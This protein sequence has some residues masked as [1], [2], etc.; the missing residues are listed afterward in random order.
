VI[1]SIEKMQKI[2]VLGGGSWGTAIAKMLTEKGYDTI[3]WMRNKEN[4]KEIIDT[5]LNKKYL[6]NILLPKELKV[7]TD[8]NKSIRD[9]DLLIFAIPTQNIRS[10]LQEIKDDIAENQIVCNVAKG[11]EA[12][13]H[14]RISQIFKEELENVRFGTL[15]GPSHAE[16][17]SKKMPTTVV[18]ASEDSYVAEY[19]QEVCMCE[20]FRVYA[21]LDLLGVEIGGALKNVI[22]LGAGI[23]DGLGY[24]DNAKAAIINRG[25]VE[26]ARLGE[27]L[28]AK[29]STFAGLSGIGDLIVTC[30]SKHSRNRKAGYLIGT[31]LC[32]EDAIKEVGMVVEGIQTAVAANGLA[33]DSNIEMPICQEIYKVL[34]DN[35]NAKN[36]VDNLMMRDKK[37]EVEI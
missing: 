9:R 15:S 4:A 27:V 2:T 6:P 33:I 19:I 21:N 13:T 16:E 14:K 26:I 25:I 22:A 31:G 34:F 32:R 1:R 10:F 3:L 29:Y 35:I 37:Y 8:K 36:A 30:A 17:V 5:R 28:G 11:L 20:Y 12:S 23:A 24:G 18:A 7:S